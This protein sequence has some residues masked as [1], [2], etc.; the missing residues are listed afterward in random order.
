MALCDLSEFSV[1]HNFTERELARLWLHGVQAIMH[2]V[3]I[4]VL[5]RDIKPGNILVTFEGY[6]QL[7]DFG[8]SS[9]TDV[10]RKTLELSL[11]TF[12]N[13]F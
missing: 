7:A 9:A 3:K 1:T 11:Y 5:H 10:R 8:I 6:I 4:H 2:L 12:I 13:S